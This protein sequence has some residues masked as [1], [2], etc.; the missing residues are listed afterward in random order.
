MPLSRK[1]SELADELAAIDDVHER[2]SLVVERSRHTPPLPAEDR[3]EANRV[4][5]CV[6]VVWLVSELRDGR[7]YFRGDAESPVV[8]GLVLFL[9][10]FFSDLPPQVVAAAE[11][12]P[13][14]ALGL[15]HNLS[16]TRSNG[17]AAVRRTMRAFAHSVSPPAG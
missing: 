10:E 11:V 16:P 17:L 3:S 5:G 12:D 14:D 9:C 8:R 15:A 2:L 1:L 6:S 13:L 7:C 4:H